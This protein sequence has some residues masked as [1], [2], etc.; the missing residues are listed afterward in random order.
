M[1]CIEK[2]EEAERQDSSQ[3][4]KLHFPTM[5]AALVWLRE[6]KAEVAIGTVVIIAGV[7]AAPYV[8]TIAAGGALVLAPL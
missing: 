8:I 2:Q 1:R 3:K 4:E 7:V 5:D 6:H